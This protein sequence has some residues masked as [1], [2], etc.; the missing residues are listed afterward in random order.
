MTGGY[1][2]GEAN[3]AASGLPS[4]TPR[5]RRN[6]ERGGRDSS[7]TTSSSRREYRTTARCRRSRSESHSDGRCGQLP[8]SLFFSSLRGGSGLP[9]REENILSSTEI[10]FSCRRTYCFD[11]QKRNFCRKQQTN[12]EHLNISRLSHRNISRL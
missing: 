7:R 9:R 3:Y 4:G 1:A 12:S 6:G 10:V 8:T 2:S 5:H 11:K